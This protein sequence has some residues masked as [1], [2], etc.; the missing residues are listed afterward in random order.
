[1]YPVRTC[2]YVILHGKEDFAGVIQLRILKRGGYPVLSCGPDEITRVLIRGKQGG[3]IQRDGVMRKA[4][5][6]ITVFEDRRQT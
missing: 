5:L 1:M 6:A 4:P 3:Q 2:E